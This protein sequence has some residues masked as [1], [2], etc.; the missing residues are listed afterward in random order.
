MK[1]AIPKGKAQEQFTDETFQAFVR[2]AG[3][4]A[5]GCNRIGEHKP[6]FGRWKTSAEQ[7]LQHCC[8]CLWFDSGSHS[9]VHV[10]SQLDSLYL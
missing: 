9:F 3:I 8:L 7:A 1:V 10:V 5:C 2:K 6:S 4:C